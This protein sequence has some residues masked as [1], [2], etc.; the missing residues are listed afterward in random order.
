MQRTEIALLYKDAKAFLN[1]EITVCGWIRTLR[2]SKT[3]GFIDLNDGSYFKGVQIVI[4]E[5]D[6]TPE[7]LTEEID[8]LASDP[9][10]LAAYAENAQRMAIADAAKRIYSV[11]IEVLSAQKSQKA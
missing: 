1:K 9:Q 4:E 3:L 8:K 6:L 2:D 5:K 10:R 7:K 11:M